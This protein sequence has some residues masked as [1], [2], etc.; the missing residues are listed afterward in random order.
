M[1]VYKVP[2]DVEAEDKLLG[3]F[4]FKQFVFLVVSV[5]ALGVAYGLSRLLL[6]LALLPLP[7]A[8]F[9]GVL[10]LPLRKD[11]PMEVYL[12]AVISFF[13]KPKKRL[14]YADGVSSL[15]EVVAPR[16]KEDNL[17]KG[18]DQQ[19][20]QRRLSYLANLVDSHG[21]SVRG[22]NDP[23]NSPMQADLYN[24]A[25]ATNDLLDE[26]SST[27]RNIDTLIN[28]AD[29][30]RRQEM[31][32][33]MQQP[34]KRVDTQLTTQKP[35][36]PPQTPTQPVAEPANL[37]INPYPTMNQSV[38][39][40]LSEATPTP[41]Q[42]QT[43]SKPTQTDQPETSKQVVDPAIIDLANNH[44]DLSIESIQR[45]ANRLNE[46]KESEEEVVISLR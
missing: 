36:N 19:E 32:N 2:Q 7:V 11:Q 46:L 4:S 39:S 41:N 9:F 33:R 15:I 42:P 26:A 16:V 38:I 5:A 40:P 17:G 21:W 20:V 45:E 22:I 29:A 3:P 18:Y 1:A 27:T 30:K 25:Q 14:W 28:Q 43:V 8:I 37:K 34:I 31:I 12:A 24:E 44:H 23:E 6:P 10:A 35:P 13:L